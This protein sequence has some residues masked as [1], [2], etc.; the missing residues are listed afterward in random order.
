MKQTKIDYK[1][2]EK[3]QEAN[4]QLRETQH[5]LGL[6][7]DALDTDLNTQKNFRIEPSVIATNLHEQMKWEILERLYDEF[8][9]DELINIAESALDTKGKIL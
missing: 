8:T 2:T 9:Y 1:L 7:Q 3:L 6:Y 4:R 5:K